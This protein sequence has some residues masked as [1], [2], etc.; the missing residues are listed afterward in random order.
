MSEFSPP[1][2]LLSTTLQ[3]EWRE[4]VTGGRNLPKNV[5]AHWSPFASPMLRLLTA[6]LLLLFSELQGDV[7]QL[8]PSI[9][10]VTLCYSAALSAAISS[11]PHFL[12]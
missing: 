5:F 11:A 1:A 3:E 10:S 9:A 12:C 4:A 6:R 2:Y 7:M 8:H